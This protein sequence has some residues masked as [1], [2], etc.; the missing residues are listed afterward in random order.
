VSSAIE[1]ADV[2]KVFVRDDAAVEVLEHV[3]L[4]IAAGSFVTLLGRSGCGK[5]TLLNMIAGLTAPT[6]GT[7]TFA[8]RPPAYPRSD[9][10]YLT[11]KETLMPWLD[12]TRNVALPLTVRG[13]PNADA[14]SRAQELIALVDLKDA[15][16]RYPRELS[17]GMQRRT[18]LARMLASDPQVLLLDEP[19]GALDS[20]L[21]AELQSELL[22][23]WQGSGKTVV[24]VTHDIDEALFMADRIIA[25]RAGGEIALDVA[26]D[27]ARPRDA[28]MIRTGPAFIALHA[29]LREAI[30]AG[31]HVLA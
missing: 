7:I 4:T 24:F 19:F 28:Q 1:L 31:A 10:G 16:T 20:Q 8:G 30:G 5:S 25:L 29:Q 22:R 27:A 26:V 11:Q 14:L 6:T 15:A 2:S 9:I 18:S 13:V 21:R 3:S 12:V 17:G 23:L